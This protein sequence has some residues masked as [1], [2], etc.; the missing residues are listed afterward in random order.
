MDENRRRTKADPEFEVLDTGVFDDGRYF[1]VQAEYAKAAPE[2]VL[3]RVTVTNRGP[4]AAR[5]HEITAD[6]DWGLVVDHP[7]LGRY[8]IDM[9]DGPAG[10]PTLLFTDNE[11]NAERLF[12][13]PSASPFTKDA[14]DRYLVG[15]RRE[16]INPERRGTKAAAHYTFEVAGGEY[17][18]HRA[19]EIGN[20]LRQWDGERARRASHR[21]ALLHRAGCRLMV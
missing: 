7:A 2:D 12:G 3:L 20:R 18:V 8:R 13:F 14:F 21:F 5:I 1:D 9:D 10:R 17:D 15:G 6:G 16:A 11:T 4:D 19:D